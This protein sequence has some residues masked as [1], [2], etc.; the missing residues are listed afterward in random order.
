[1]PELG[2]RAKVMG[3]QPIAQRKPTPPAVTQAA[4]HVLKLFADGA[5]AELE[6]LA[7]PAAVSAVAALGAAAH[8]GAYDKR[9]AIAMARINQHYYLKA[10]LT[11]PNVQPLIAQMRLG[12]HDGRWMIWEANNLTGCRSG[13]SR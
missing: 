9:E 3:P 4:E 6:A 2:N 12:E 13:W 5:C 8:A 7:M 11:G 1:M 10:R